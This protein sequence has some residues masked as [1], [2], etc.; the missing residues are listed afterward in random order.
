MTTFSRREV[1]RLLPACALM[2]LLAGC[3]PAPGLRVAG[4]VWPGYEPLFLARAEGWLDE[5]KASL[6]ET[7]SASES[8]QALAAGRADGA[9]LTLDEVLRARAGGVPLSVVLVFDLSA[10]ADMLL[11][12]PGIERL[13]DL[14]G[15]RIGVEEGAVGALMLVHVLRE[16][17]LSAGEV[18]R[19]AL[20]IDRHEAAWREGALDA[21]VTFEPVAGRLMQGGA[22]RIFDSRSLPDAIADVLAIR[23]DA[24][25]GGGEAARHLVAAHLRGLAHL[26]SHPQ[27]AAHRMAPRLRLPPE[28]VLA[29]FRGLVLP[30][31]DNNR[32]LLAGA[33]PTLLASARRLSAL[34]ASSGLLPAEDALAGLLRPEFLPAGA[35]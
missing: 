21:L 17:G 27:D 25:D 23:T 11:A 22:R 31:R 16:A 33:A 29:A 28:R 13:A 4:H 8:M 7:A 15:R 5:R 32:R 20:P 14:K 12:R 9:A 6:L 30:D 2:P 19:V 35:A 3:G 10:G 18:T 24:L 34:M 1:L 26:A